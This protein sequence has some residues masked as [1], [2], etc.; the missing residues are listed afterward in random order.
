[1]LPSEGTQ[2]G[3]IAIRNTNV[4]NAYLSRQLA[5]AVLLAG[6]CALKQADIV[7]SELLGVVGNRREVESSTRW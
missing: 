1:L 7:L 5:V 3:I 6:F 2:R 4:A